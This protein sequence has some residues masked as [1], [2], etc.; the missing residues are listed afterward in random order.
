MRVVNPCIS[1]HGS[2]FKNRP[3]ATSGFA[4]KYGPFRPIGLVWGEGSH[5]YKKHLRKTHR[6]LLSFVRLV[7]PSND[8]LRL[9]TT[10]IRRCDG[11]GRS[12]SSP[13]RIRVDERFRQ[14]IS[15][16][17]PRSRCRGSTSFVKRKRERSR[18]GSTEYSFPS[19]GGEKMKIETA[20]I[21]KM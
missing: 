12:S 8:Q 20:K 19:A 15:Y 14:S 4:S 5:L 3:G 9:Q 17:T 1:A 18:K 11:E 7:A 6:L 21:K 16:S 10:T 13:S 2:I